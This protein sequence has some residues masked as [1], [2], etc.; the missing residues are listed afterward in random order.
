VLFRSAWILPYLE[1]SAAYEKFSLFDPYETQPEAARFLVVNTFLCPSRRDASQAIAQDTETRV[2]L[3]CG[4][5]GGEMIAVQGGA[6]GDY[7][8]NHGD[9]TGGSTGAESDYW[10]GGN[11][12]G[13]LI[14]SRGQCD[15]GQVVTWIDRVRPADI[16]DGLSN[17]ALAGEMHVPIDR[18][19][20]PPENGAVFN[21]EDIVAF[22][23]IGGPGVPLAKG[24]R[25]LAYTAA[26]API[27]NPNPAS[28]IPV[29]G[30][31]SWHPGICHFVLADGS[32][33]G[34]HNTIDT[35]SLG[36][37]THRSNP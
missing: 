6:V 15:S 30:F 9:F 22:A 20:Q 3:P 26:R 19:A 31:G 2:T 17:T 12:T 5:G 33:R 13:V 11:G 7:A 36:Q 32:V 14:S 25:D 23:R 28:F 10:R 34:V 8:G 37:L 24:P 27:T 35:I 1:Q 21:G 18:L 16:R 29:R 4:C